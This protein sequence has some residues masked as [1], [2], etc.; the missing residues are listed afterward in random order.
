LL[1]HSSGITSDGKVPNNTIENLFDLASLK[2]QVKDGISFF[3]TSETVKYSNFG[4]ALLG[5]IIEAISGQTYEEYIQNTILTKLEMNNTYPDYDDS[6]SSLRA[7]GYKMR[8]PG[9]ERESYS[10]IPVGIMKPAAGLSSNVEDLIKFYQ[11]HILGNESLIP[12]YIKR[13]M[14][15]IQFKMNNENRGLGFSLSTN[16]EAGIITHIGVILDLE[17]CRDL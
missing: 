7:T 9:R 2:K 14:H 8:Y 11:S 12:D 13:E 6:N 4:F 1:T 10:Q 16:P 3:K 15:R 5:L 17:Q